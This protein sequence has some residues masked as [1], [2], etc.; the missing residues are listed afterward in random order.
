MRPFGKR[1]TGGS[2]RWRWPDKIKYSPGGRKAAPNNPQSSSVWIDSFS[3][4]SAGIQSL[5]V[6][7]GL[8]IGAWWALQTFIFQNPAYYEQ[9]REVVGAEPD[10]VRADLSVLPLDQVT[11][12]Y[13]VT[14]TVH[15]ASKTLSQLVKP[16]LFVITFFKPTE[17]ETHTAHFMS[18][19][20][21][22]AEIDVPA[23]ESR[24][25]RYLAEFPGDGTYILEIN[26]CEEQHHNC[27][28]QKMVHVSPKEINAASLSSSS[29]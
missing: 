16:D 19:S 20:N 27:L 8:M 7:I 21:F 29:F 23:G 9:G 24:D 5:A 3:K 10:F 28:A 17:K 12:Q 15:N 11:R 4:L 14:L 13:E 26:L 1:M 22:D 2:T 6:V 25:F 18:R